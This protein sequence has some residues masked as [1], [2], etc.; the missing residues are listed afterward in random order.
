MEQYNQLTETIIGCGIRV[1]KVLGPG[2]LESAYRQ[3][4]AYELHKK[5]LII[6]EE[7]PMPV[8][9]DEIRLN[10]GYRLDLLVENTVV[11]E[12]KTVE[13]FSEVHQAQILTYMRLGAFPIG[14]LMNFNVTA[15][16]NGIKRYVLG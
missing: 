7:K 1:H 10:Q 6:E 3:C 16:K 9:Y 4:L 12:L 13:A 15:L 11:I 14:L 8:I 2:M 5:G